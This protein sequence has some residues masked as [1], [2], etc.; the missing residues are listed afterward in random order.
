MIEVVES[1]PGEYLITVDGVPVARTND[2]EQAAYLAGA[3]LAKSAAHAANAM[4]P[5]AAEGPSGFPD[6]VPPIAA[7]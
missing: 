7:C 5:P 6:P 3:L 4:T 1:T 2:P